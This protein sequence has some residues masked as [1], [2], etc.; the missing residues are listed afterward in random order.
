MDKN[1]VLDSV[2]KLLTT[3][4]HT[5]RQK[6]P[7]LRDRPIIITLGAVHIL[8]NTVGGGGGEI[9]I[10]YTPYKLKIKFMRFLLRSGRGV[11]KGRFLRYVIYGP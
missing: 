5:Y 11:Q 10:C 2:Y 9:E 3:H 7:Q 4:I 6:F 8:R 1:Y